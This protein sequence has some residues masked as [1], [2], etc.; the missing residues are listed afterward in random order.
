MYI[1]LR[2]LEDV[3]FLGWGV[4]LGNFIGLWDG[5]WR[6]NWE[7]KERWLIKKCMFYWFIGGVML[8]G[9][10]GNLG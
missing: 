6:I 10:F 2:L 1:Y 7:G 8:G 5:L 4:G 9:E 3:R